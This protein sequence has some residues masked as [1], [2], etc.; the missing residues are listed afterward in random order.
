MGGGGER[1]GRRGDDD[2]GN[3]QGN[4]RR[5]R[6]RQQ[7]QRQRQQCATPRQLTPAVTN[8]EL[9]SSKRP[10][11]ASRCSTMTPSPPTIPCRR[12]RNSGTSST[13]LLSASYARTMPSAKSRVSEAEPPA[14][15]RPPPRSLA[16]CTSSS[17]S[18]STRASNDHTP[19]VSCAA[20]MAIDSERAALAA[21]EVAPIEPASS[22]SKPCT[23]SFPLSL[24]VAE[25]WSCSLEARSRARVRASAARVAA[26]ARPALRA[27]ARVLR[28]PCLHSSA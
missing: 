7:R 27:P 11:S 23:R 13:P 9:S 12:A 5:K 3:G 4:G 28:R 17:S 22:S 21:P 24:R 2:D 6:P 19:L 14:L 25:L 20:L 10:A 16:F 26:A 18:S 8:P 15:P 1:G